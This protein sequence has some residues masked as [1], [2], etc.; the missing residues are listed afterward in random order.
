MMSLCWCIMCLALPIALM[1]SLCWCLSLVLVVVCGVILAS[2]TSSG[3]RLFWL[4]FFEIV[5]ALF[6]K[7][8]RISGFVA[9]H[10]LRLGGFLCMLVLNCFCVGM[11]TLCLMR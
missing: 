3:S 6:W 9:S 5:A 11:S 8:F 10:P 2:L 7:K 4:L 1:I